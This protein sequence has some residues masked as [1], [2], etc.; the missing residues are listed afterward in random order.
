[1]GDIMAKLKKPTLSMNNKEKAFVYEI[2]GIVSL[3]VSII[4]LAR[5]GLIGKYLVLAFGLLFGD[6]YFIFIVLVGFFGIYCL[7]F[8]KRIELKSVRYYGI[9]LILS[10]LLVITHFSM[11]EYV[12]Q[13]EGNS[14]KLTINIYFDYFKSNNLSMIKGG[15]IIGCILFYIFYYLLGGVGAIIISILI[16]MI[17]IVFLTKKTIKEFVEMIFNVFKKVYLFFNNRYKSLIKNVKEISNDYLTKENKTPTKRKLKKEKIKDNVASDLEYCEKVVK[18]L[19]DTFIKLDVNIENISY[20]I[21]EHI[22]VFFIKA[23]QEINYKV[24]EYEIRDKIK[25]DFLIKYDKIN[26]QIILELSKENPKPLSFN[27]AIK[28]IDEKKNIIV[29]GIDDRNIIVECTDNILIIAENQNLLKKYIMSVYAFC[30]VQKK[31]DFNDIVILDFYKKLERYYSNSINVITDIDYLNTIIE[32]VD[33]NLELLNLHHKANIDEYNLLYK[34]KIKKKYYIIYGIEDLIYQKNYFDKLLY[35]VQTGRLAGINLILSL[36]S[37][38]FLSNI[39]LGSIDKKILLKN[40]FE[41]S[42][43]VIDTSYMDVLN[44]EVEAFYKDKDLLIRISLL[45]MSDDEVNKYYPYKENN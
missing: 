39:L 44:E 34:N 2:I 10:S 32:E 30:S 38:V 6:W 9:I 27:K 43:K 31:Y 45:L 41:V 36:S 17:G 21:C 13:F 5:F 25:E 11:H 8:H 3:L 35:I 19:K 18:I 42:E 14:L 33:Q 40:K 37:N 12:S 29:L 4:S 28:E 26:E 7:V 20:I 16:F 23:K 1:M 24:L 22:F 15:G